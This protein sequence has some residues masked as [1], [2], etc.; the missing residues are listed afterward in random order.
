MTLQIIPVEGKAALRR[1]IGLP[2]LL[3]SG[4]PGFVAPL[5]MDR[6]S[7]LDPAKGA[8]FRTGR[9]QYWLA[10]RDGKDVGRISAQITPTLPLHVPGGSGHFGA[11][12]ARDDPEA[13]AALLKTAESWLVAQGCTRAFGPCML[14]MNE[15]PGLLVAGHEDPPMIMAPW[16]PAY[17]E[18]HLVAAGYRP[19]KDLHNWRMDKS[20]ATLAPISERARRNADRMQITIRGLDL[21]NLSQ[22]LALMCELFNDAWSDNWGFSPLALEDL[23]AVEKELKPFVKPEMGIIIAMRGRP[24]A[25]LMIV[26]NLFELTGD[27]G[28]DPSILG[29]VRLGLRSLRPRFRSGRVI[30]MGVRKE[31]RGS[32]GGAAIAMSLIDETIRRFQGQDWDRVEAGWVL[33]DNHNLNSILEA[34]GFRRCKTFRLFDKALVSG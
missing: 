14:S 11:L 24:V 20:Q 22:D 29:W 16:H 1:F 5:R 7:I 25:V 32:V 23:A 17:L 8:F 27:L 19:I 31:L 12:D 30:L 21:R 18:R 15:E 33:D 26:P 13:I 34:S 9:A 3:Y 10:R 2:P 28:A 4:M 6:A